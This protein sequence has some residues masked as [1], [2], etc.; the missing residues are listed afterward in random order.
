M[1][2]IIAVAVWCTVAGMPQVATLRTTAS[3]KQPQLRQAEDETAHETEV[4]APSAR[5]HVIRAGQH[6]LIFP[7]DGAFVED[8]LRDETRALPFVLA[9]DHEDDLIVERPVRSISLSPTPVKIRTPKA[10]LTV[11]MPQ[12]AQDKINGDDDDKSKPAHGQKMRFIVDALEPDKSVESDLRNGRIFVVAAKKGSRET[13]I[14]QLQAGPPM[15]G[16]SVENCEEVIRHWWEAIELAAVRP[17]DPDVP[18]GKSGVLD[19]I[20][21]TR[22]YYEETGFDFR[23]PFVVRADEYVLLFPVIKAETWL[24]ERRIPFLLAAKCPEPA[25]V[26]STIRFSRMWPGEYFA[27]GDLLIGNIAPVE[28]A[29]IVEQTGSYFGKDEYEL[30]ENGRMYVETMKVLL[31][32][33]PTEEPLEC[34]LD[35]GR[36]FLISAAADTRKM[37]LRQLQMR[38][39]QPKALA[40]AD[41]N[42][43]IAATISSVVSWWRLTRDC[44]TGTL[45]RR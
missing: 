36:V 23:G 38:I 35:E 39:V 5:T 25:N 2:P 28:L 11:R 12:S 16:I 17:Q 9:V 18:L 33:S 4:V 22:M 15:R 8:A 43:D 13:T 44:E 3:D 29:Y 1:R 31:P 37:D 20:E 42:L 19:F 41:G 26:V 32:G 30:D 14:R 27:W 24:L 40:S 10:T 21:P 34:D 7:F 6:T 45:L